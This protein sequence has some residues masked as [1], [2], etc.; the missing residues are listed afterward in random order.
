MIRKIRESSHERVRQAIGKHEVQQRMHVLREGL[1]DSR[2]EHADALEDG[3][4]CRSIFP[5]V[6]TD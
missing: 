3:R 1:A 5:A 6:G 2:S 4:F